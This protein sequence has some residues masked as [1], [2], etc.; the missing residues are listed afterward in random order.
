MDELYILLRAATPP[1]ITLAATKTRPVDIYLMRTR[2]V[3]YI[4]PKESSPMNFI[5]S[6]I[7]FG[8]FRV[9]QGVPQCDCRLVTPVDPH[10][11]LDSDV[12]KRKWV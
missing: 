4:F 7:A 3:A 9:K 2:F 1:R 5:Q 10:A 6:N 8:Q 11:V 12:F